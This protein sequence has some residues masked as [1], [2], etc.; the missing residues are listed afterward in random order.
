MQEGRLVLYMSGFI[1]F[2]NGL[3]EEKGKQERFQE[4]KYF[5]FLIVG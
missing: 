3:G 2:I 4:D 5:F 1:L